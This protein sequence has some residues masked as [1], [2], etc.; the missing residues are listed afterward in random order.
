[1]RLSA[2]LGAEFAGTFVLVFGGTGSAVLAATFLTP[3]ARPNRYHRCRHDHGHNRGQRA[4]DWLCRCFSRVWADGRDDGVCG[5]SP[6]RRTL[7]PG[8]HPWA[9]VRQALRVEGRDSI[10]RDTGGRCA[11]RLR[12]VVGHRHQ[13]TR[14][15]RR[16]R[17]QP[18]VS[19]RTATATTRRASTTSSPVSS[20]RLCSRRSS[21]S[22]SW[23]RPTNEPRR[24]SPRWPS[25]S[26]SRS[27]TSSASR[28]PTR[29]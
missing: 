2:R 8:D 14:A 25:A 12:H 13:P 28:S 6:V 18:G 1:M 5:R 20:S 21:S 4:G 23:A 7:Q 29:R 27:S 15:P 3:W 16:T 9:C 22:S 11:R 17:S 10:R 19:R 24:A 26:P